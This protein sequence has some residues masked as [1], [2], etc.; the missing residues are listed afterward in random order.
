MIRFESDDRAVVSSHLYAW[1][2]PLAGGEDWELWGRYEDVVV[3]VGGEWW[4][5]ERRLLVA[6]V[7]GFPSDWEWLRVQRHDVS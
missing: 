1:H 2:R 7:V 3:R 5:H 6:G 4:I